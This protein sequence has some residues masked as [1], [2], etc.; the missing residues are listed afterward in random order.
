MV[1]GR[2]YLFFVWWIWSLIGCDTRHQAT[3]ESICSILNMARLPSPWGQPR[4]WLV[5]CML[6]P[7]LWHFP[8]SSQ[9]HES[10]EGPAM[11]LEC[12]A[13]SLGLGKLCITYAH[14]VGSCPFALVFPLTG[15]GLRRLGI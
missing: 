6:V 5:K 3:K 7:Q 13:A 4:S 14:M 8:A 10:Q 1:I 12:K 15:E 9:C 11:C 2:C